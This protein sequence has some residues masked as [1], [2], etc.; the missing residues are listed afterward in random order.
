MFLEWA[1]YHQG[2]GGVISVYLIQMDS[3]YRDGDGDNDNVFTWCLAMS[4]DAC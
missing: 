1:E 3:Q 2:G 4:A